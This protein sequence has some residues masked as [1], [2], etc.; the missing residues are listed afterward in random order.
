MRA[1]LIIDVQN[2]FCPGGALA[3]NGGD[4]IIKGI[5]EQM[6]EYDLVVASQDWHPANHGSFASNQG[7]DPGEVIE[8]NG[9]PQILWPDHCVQNSK[10]AEFHSELNLDKVD[11]VFTKGEDPRVDSYSAFFDNDKRSETGLHKYLEEKGVTEVDVCGLAIDYCVKY[12]ALDAV[13]LGYRTRI[14]E[15]LSRGVE[16]NKGD[17]EKS[18]REMKEKGVQ[19][20]R[21][22]KCAA[23]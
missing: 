15:N 2:D 5:N 12:T 10:G 22:E 8:L 1:L 16:L 13:M 11:K 23:D 9:L 19:V 17:I 14:I 4:E 7:K 3:V 18:L 21:Y 20:L 6:N